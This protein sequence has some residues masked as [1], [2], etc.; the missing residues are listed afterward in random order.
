ML[1][2][3]QWH[4]ITS[5]CFTQN[6]SVCAGI[7]LRKEKSTFDRVSIALDKEL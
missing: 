4:Y 5:L 7:N 3:K 1:V 6:L 2:N